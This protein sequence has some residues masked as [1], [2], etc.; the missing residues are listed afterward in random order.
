L[1]EIL[2]PFRQKKTLLQI[3][4]CALVFIGMAVPFKVMVLIEG[5]TEVRPVNAVPV[6]AGLLFGPAGAWG[7]AAGNLIADLFGTFSKG[8]V[9]GFI[10]NFI[11]AYLP[12][13]LWHM[14]KKGEAPNAKSFKNIGIYVFIS[15]VGA[16]STAILIACGLDVF[17]GLWSPQLF[18]IICL[19]DF[20]FPLFLGLPVLIVLTCEDNKVAAY[21]PP[22]Q[23]GT[24]MLKNASLA[25]SVVSAVSLSVMVFLGLAMSGSLLMLAFGA[26]FLLSTGVLVV[27]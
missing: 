20:L 22:G 10:G 6:V 2:S 8:S 17:F 18:A 19:N 1:Q 7:C 25:L 5:L 27:L 24:S 15:A 3:G 12:Y 26:L 13:K 11:A 4:L 14:F 21:L 16:L 23:T 9:L